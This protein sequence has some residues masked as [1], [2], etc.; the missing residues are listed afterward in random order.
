MQRHLI[1][2]F[3]AAIVTA[4]LAGNADAHNN[5]LAEQGLNA[6]I[7]HYLTEGHHLAAYALIGLLGGAALAVL[8][9]ARRWAIGAWASGGAVAGMAVIALG[10]A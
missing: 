7:S 8:R 6:A 2:I 5:L 4:V 9:G 1:W 3:A 10:L